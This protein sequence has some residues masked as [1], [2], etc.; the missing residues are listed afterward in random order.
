L[1]ADD[2]EIRTILGLII[3]KA[4]NEPF[5]PIKQSFEGLEILQTTG[6]RSGFAIIKDSQTNYVAR[7]SNPRSARS[8][9]GPV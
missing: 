5:V 7:A 3:L 9:A 6:R 4:S 2:Q 8:S 1:T